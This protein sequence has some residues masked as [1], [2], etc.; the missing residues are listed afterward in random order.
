MA[1]PLS[2]LA[3]EILR[4]A[5][6][7]FPLSYT[8]V[9]KWKRLRVSA[10][11]AYYRIGTIGLSSLILDT[12]EKLRQTLLHEYAHLLAVDR[13]G[14]KAANHGVY[15]KQ[16]MV[17]LGVEPKVRHNY[18]CVRNTARQTVTYRCQKCGAHIQRSRKLP[19]NRRYVHARCGGGLRMLSVKSAT[20]E[21]QG[22]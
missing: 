10:G 14:R 18:E 5:M 17:D 9:V 1:H 12:P 2:D 7:R 8:P 20:A 19:R 15:W 4:E 6:A 21:V 3:E 11:M 13:H 16:A 22:A